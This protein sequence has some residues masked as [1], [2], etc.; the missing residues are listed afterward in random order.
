MREEAV[1]QDALGLEFV[2]AVNDGD[3]AGEMVRKRASS[4]AVLPPPMTEHLRSR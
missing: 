3:F 1:L 2:A 4:T